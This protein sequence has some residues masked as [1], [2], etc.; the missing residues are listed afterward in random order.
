[1][2]DAL[3]LEI[4]DLEPICRLSTN[5]SR[6]SGAFPPRFP[7]A[8]ASSTSICWAHPWP[9]LRGARVGASWIARSIRLPPR[10]PCAMPSTAS[11]LHRPASA[12]SSS[13][14]STPTTW[15]RPA[16]G[17][18]SPAHP[19]TCSPPRS[20]TWPHSGATPP[21][22]PSSMSPASASHMACPPT[23]PRRSSPAPSNCAAC[24]IC[25]TILRAARPRPAHPSGRCAAYR[26]L[27]TPGHADGHLSPAARR[28]RARRWRRRAARS[29]PHRRLVSLVAPRSPC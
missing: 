5:W 3:P 23:R 1:M 13:L 26:A 2:Q 20:A 28:R 22:P 7:S 12:P 24:S 21:T 19:S 6:A 27:W 8:P 10:L 15:A 11:A 29:T 14:T 16:A 9:P 25:L 17:S 18:G 4:A